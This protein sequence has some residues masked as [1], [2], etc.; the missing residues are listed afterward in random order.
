MEKKW[1]RAG[2]LLLVI[3]SVY[4]ILS[5]VMYA[6]M[7]TLPHRRIDSYYAASALAGACMAAVGL[8]FAVAGAVARPLGD[9]QGSTASARSERAMLYVLMFGLLWL[10]NAVAAVSV[11]GVS[12]GAWFLALAVA[13]IVACAYKL[14]AINRQR[15]SEQA[16]ADS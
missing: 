9:Q 4:A 11:I 12:R 16:P 5:F 1:F 10:A 13:V 2:L 8:A 14:A 7:L 6:L 15:R 3:S